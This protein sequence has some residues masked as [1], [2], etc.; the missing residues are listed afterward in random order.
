MA[1]P[2]FLR[3]VLGILTEAYAAVVSTPD[4]IVA[5]GPDGKI[6]QSFMPTGVGPDTVQ[7]IASEALADGDLVNIWSNGGVANV[8]KATAAVPGKEANGFVLAGYLASATATVYR[9]GENSHVTALV[10]GSV[11]FLSA[12]AG[13]ST[14]VA[15]SG[16][17]QV[18]Q[19]IG[20]ASG[21]TNLLFNPNDPISLV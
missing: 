1:A 15:P 2:K 13:L 3:Q 16:A 18:V 20:V 8:R 17:G 10:P 14:N 4:S 7:V 11:Q 19:R 9:E 21:A 5:T 12:T 6:D